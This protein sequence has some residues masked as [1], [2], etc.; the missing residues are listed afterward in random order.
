MLNLDCLEM[1]V[2]ASQLGKMTIMPGQMATMIQQL[3]V[4]INELVAQR[5]NLE[6]MRD[7]TDWLPSKDKD[8]ARRKA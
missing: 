6:S 4:M 7:K 3:D 2:L 1:Q 8:K 5:R